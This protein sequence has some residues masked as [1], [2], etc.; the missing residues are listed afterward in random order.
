MS[1]LVVCVVPRIPALEFFHLSG[2]IDQ[3][4]SASPPWMT[5]GTDGDAELWDRRAGGIGR[6][7][8]AHNRGLTV[9]GMPSSLH[10]YSS[11]GVVAGTDA[12]HGPLAERAMTV[13]PHPFALLYS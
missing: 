10:I 12:P 13:L 7:T 5:R 9:R 8:R 11:C 1:F 3:L 4:L 6:A 2:G